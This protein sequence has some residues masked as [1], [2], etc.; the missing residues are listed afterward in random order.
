M[1]TCF[2]PTLS[3]GSAFNPDART[4]SVLEGIPTRERG[5]EVIVV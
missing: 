5:N 1:S 4:Q 2:V 3:V